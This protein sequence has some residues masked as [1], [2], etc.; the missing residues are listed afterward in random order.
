MLLVNNG[1]ELFISGKRY[2]NLMKVI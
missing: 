2:N 1:K